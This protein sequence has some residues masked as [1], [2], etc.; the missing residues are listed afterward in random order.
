[1]LDFNKKRKLVLLVLVISTCLEVCKSTVVE[2]FNDGEDEFEIKAGLTCDLF[3]AY[4]VFKHEDGTRSCA[5][6]QDEHLASM[7]DH[8]SHMRCIKF[9]DYC[10]VEYLKNRKQTVRTREKVDK[11]LKMEFWNIVSNNKGK[12]VDLTSELDDVI[13]IKRAGRLNVRATKK[14]YKGQ[15]IKISMNKDTC[16][17]LIGEG[18]IT[19]PFDFNKIFPGSIPTTTTTTTTPPTTTTISPTTTTKTTTTTTMVPVQTTTPSTTLYTPTK[20]TSTHTKT[21]S[22]QPQTTTVYKSSTNAIRTSSTENHNTSPLIQ[23]T[24][25]STDQPVTRFPN[26][27]KETADEKTSFN[28][29]L[30][31][32]LVIFSVIALALIVVVS[33]LCKRRAKAPSKQAQSSIEN[34]IYTV[35]ATSQNE[36]LYLSPIDFMNDAKMYSKSGQDG[37][38]IYSD[39]GHL[40]QASRTGSFNSLITTSTNNSPQVQRPSPLVVCDTESPEGLYVGLSQNATVGQTEN[41]YQTLPSS[42]FTGSEYTALSPDNSG[43]I[44]ATSEPMYRE[45]YEDPNSPGGSSNTYIEPSQ[46]GGNYQS[47]N[48]QN[49]PPSIYHQLQNN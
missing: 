16:L 6:D 42:S 38:N 19:Y 18:D 41:N 11:I 45:V 30:I 31:A 43:A 15:L 20:K 7:D 35:P 3:N 36:N 49:E 25:Y 4:E 9:K 10:N 2:R 8:G 40:G 21:S 47:L 14:K 34:P 32:G 44:E 23:S 13:R 37:A 22:L 48:L 24:Q 17:Y 29:G 1:M 28:I 27:Q 46:G 33:I 39:I 26:N 12:W 5:C